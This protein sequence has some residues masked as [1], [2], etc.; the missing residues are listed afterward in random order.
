MQ[1]VKTTY[2]G[3]S[4]CLMAQEPCFPSWSVGTYQN[5]GYQVTAVTA[6]LPMHVPLPVSSSTVLAYLSPTSTLLYKT[7]SLLNC[8]MYL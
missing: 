6:L 1:Q 7:S 3:T 5:N 8:C 4:L 2:P